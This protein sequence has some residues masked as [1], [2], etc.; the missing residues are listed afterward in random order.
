MEEQL[1][2]KI[3]GDGQI[4][5]FAVMWILYYLLIERP[6][7]VVVMT[8]GGV[9]IIMLAEAVVL[10]PALFIDVP[11]AMVVLFHGRARYGDE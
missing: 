11:F 9:L 2:A 1:P 5:G 4:W 3:R 8:Y 6:I 10:H 7:W